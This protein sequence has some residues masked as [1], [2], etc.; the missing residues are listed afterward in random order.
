MLPLQ[1]DQASTGWPHAFEVRQGQTPEA[2]LDTCAGLCL[3]P[4]KPLCRQHTALVSRAHGLV[5][6]AAAPKHLSPYAG[7][8]CDVWK[9]QRMCPPLFSF[10][11]PS[12]PI[13]LDPCL[14]RPQV[15]L[16]L[17]PDVGGS[18]TSSY[19]EVVAKL[20]R[21]KV[22]QTEEGGGMCACMCACVCSCMHACMHINASALKAPEHL[23]VHMCAR[24]QQALACTHKTY[25][26][27]RHTNTH[28]CA[29]GQGLRWRAR[30]ASGKRQVCALAVRGHDFRRA[31]RP[32]RPQLPQL[33]LWGDP[34][35]RG[36]GTIKTVL[37]C[38]PHPRSCSPHMR[39]M[40]TRAPARTAS[41]QL[42]AASP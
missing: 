15:Y 17:C 9:V 27:S 23:C 21:T 20:A 7:G 38:A 35:S 36:V 26:L 42:W 41:T 5:S 33:A 28:L 18:V 32:Q 40:R 3:P 11:G 2:Q 31:R 14:P 13:C 19:E 30:G 12:P 1:P 39:P 4:G 25:T 37:L 22:R 16:A 24:A 8:L 6:G 34:C 29:G 10:P